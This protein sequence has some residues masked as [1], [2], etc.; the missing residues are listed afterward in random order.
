MKISAFSNIVQVD[1][2]TL[3]AKMAAFWTPNTK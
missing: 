3:T 2:K 1:P